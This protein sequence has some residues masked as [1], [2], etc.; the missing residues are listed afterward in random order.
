MQVAKFIEN[1]SRLTAALASASVGHDAVGAEVVAATHNADEAANLVGSDSGW[2][3]VAV[4]LGEREVDVDGLF[5]IFGGS[6]EAWKVEIGIRTSHNI[7][8][9]VANEGFFHS[10]SHAANNAHYEVAATLLAH[11]S[12]LAE[13]REYLLLGIVANGAS[14]DK[15]G[16][17]G[18]NLLRDVV[19]SHFH[20]RSNDFAISHIHLAAVGLNEELF[21]VG[22]GGRVG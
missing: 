2:N 3:H 8:T 20:H 11:C 18:F 1:A 14:V 16:I 17:G 5:A 12:E 15:D 4:G 7:H 22:V 9:V 21:A 13:A 6:E 19:A 10:L